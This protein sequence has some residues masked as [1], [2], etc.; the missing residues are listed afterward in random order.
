MHPHTA[1]PASWVLQTSLLPGPSSSHTKAVLYF[2]RNTF[3]GSSIGSQAGGAGGK[4]DVQ[5]AGELTHRATVLG[6]VDLQFSAEHTIK[7]V[8]VC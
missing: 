6:L 4:A 5:Q 2:S 8:L 3:W 7:W 1:L